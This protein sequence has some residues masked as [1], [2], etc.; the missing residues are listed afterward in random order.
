[1]RIYRYIYYRVSSLNL[2]TFGQADLSQFNACMGLA[3]FAV[4]NLLSLLVVTDVTR[5]LVSK[6]IVLALIAASFAAHHLYFVKS[7]RC[8]HLSEEFAENAPFSG[9]AGLAVVWLYAVGSLA[10]FFCIIHAN[11][12]TLGI[13]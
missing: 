12:N 4:V 1:M 11:R 7:G 9:R 3:I 8:L 13:T 6:P 2:G 5:G 10:L